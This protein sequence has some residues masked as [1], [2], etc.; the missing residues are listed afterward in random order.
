MGDYPNF[1]ANDN[2]EIRY[3]IGDRVT[4]DKY[5]HDFEQVFHQPRPFQLDALSGAVGTIKEIIPGRAFA[6]IEGLKELDCYK[7]VFDKPIVNP[8]AGGEPIEDTVCTYR[9]F[10][11]KET[12]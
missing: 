6:N 1:P 9:D 4:I 8:N 12:K 10:M 5:A 2:Y 11:P 7:V 3:S